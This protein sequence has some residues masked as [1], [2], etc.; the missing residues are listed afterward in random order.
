[1]K[2]KKICL[3][4]GL[5]LLVLL[6]S[7]TGCGM[8]P[9]AHATDLMAD[10]TAN[11]LALS[12]P[13]PDFYNAAKDFSFDLFRQTASDENPLISPLSVLLALGMTAN[14]ADTHTLAEFEDVLGNGLPLQTLNEGYAWLIENLPSTSK[15]KLSL[16]NSIWIREDTSPLPA[17][18]QTNA[19]YYGASAYRADFQDPQTV[20]DLNAWVKKHTDGQIDKVMEQ[21]KPD[22]VML[23]VNALTFDAEWAKIYEEYQVRD[24]EFANLSG[25]KTAVSMMHSE[26]AI[27]LKD[28]LATGFVKPYAQGY[29]FV[30]LLPNE[31]IAFADY[32]NALDG[33]R[34]ASLWENAENKM[35]YAGLPKF[36]LSYEATLND[37]LS[38][39]GLSS[40]F[41]DN[42][43]FSRL[44]DDRGLA[45]DEVIHKTKIDVDE[46]GTKAGAVTV[47]AIR[48][49]AH[50]IGETVLLDRPFVYAIVENETGLPVFLGAVTDL[51][52]K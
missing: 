17:F 11:K 16:A 28:D 15:A 21:I 4:S 41:S 51:P 52:A 13:A 8:I 39:M 37:A 43:D 31:G 33:E 48:E 29:S 32:V 22:I 18:L 30:A 6:P 35:V 23:L 9:S 25:Q 40:A 12:A 36:S 50:V 2:L 26:E 1:M 24:G 3:L 44:M 38:A 14:G 47:V 19:D 34:F 46:K 10:V 20:K 45:I 42:A 27:F 49:T 5:I 7:L